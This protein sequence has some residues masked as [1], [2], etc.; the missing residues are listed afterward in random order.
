MSHLP[1][2]GPRGEGWVAVQVV[3][4]V[5]VVLTGLLGPAWNGWPRIATLAIGL[6]LI[7]G[8]S[9]LALWGIVDLRAAL[10]PLPYPRPDAELV[11]TGAYRWVRHPIYGG[12]VLAAFGWGLATAS[13]PALV[14][15]AALLGFFELKAR[16]EE[17]WL[18]DRFPGYSAYRA[19]TRR[20]IPWIG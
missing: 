18:V 13:P 8:G 9:S 16:R 19:H 20:L 7:A 12:L 5:L 3:L 17:A 4:I 6:A 10:T 2:L 15:A 14:L 1:S 11:I